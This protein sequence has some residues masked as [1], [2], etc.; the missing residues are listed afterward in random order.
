METMGY[1]VPSWEEFQERGFLKYEEF[2][3]KPQFRDWPQE[4][5][6]GKFPTPSGKIELY[7]E[8]LDTT[9]PMEPLSGGWNEMTV[10]GYPLPGV[11]KYTP[12]TRGMDTPMVK[13]YPLMMLTSHSRHHGF[14]SH[15]WNP[16]IQGEVTGQRLWIS[17][18]D[19]E[20][21]G[22]KDGD[23]VLITS[24]TGRVAIPAYVTNRMTPGVVLCRYGAPYE[25]NA[26][27]I[28]RGGN[29]NTLTN[30]IDGAPH[31]PA[32]A[33]QLVKVEKF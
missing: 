16:M 26:Q 1:T 17:S 21:R 8:Y 6:D 28:D 30:P 10:L 2:L 24:D 13:E 19:A 25:P 4:I 29:C 27:G 33:S 11:P 7:S 23:M 5:A 20:T 9:D 18:A 31:W 15:Y 22:I 14:S 12:T 32:N 3:D